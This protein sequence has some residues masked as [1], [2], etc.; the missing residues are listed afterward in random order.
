VLVLREV[1]VSHIQPSENVLLC[2]LLLTA[3]DHNV[4]ATLPICL[5]KDDI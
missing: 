3:I 5:A 1:E 4:L 2:V